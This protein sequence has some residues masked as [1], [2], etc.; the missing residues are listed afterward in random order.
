MPDRDD[1]SQP[2]AADTSGYP[3]YAGDTT[4]VD[5]QPQTTTDLDVASGDEL[6]RYTGG[7][8]PVDVLD[9]P[10]L[11]ADFYTATDAGGYA[12]T[13][14]YRPVMV[15]GIAVTGPC[16]L[17][18]YNFIDTTTGATAFLV[19]IHDGLDA[20]APPVAYVN[21]SNPQSWPNLPLR[22]RFGCYIEFVSGTPRGHIYT[23]G[24]RAK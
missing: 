12:T 10:N 9:D 11:A 23:V 8:A 4:M 13:G 16:Y 19:I 7:V 6:A 1:I 3:S 5:S 2:P 20:A 14:D 17:A 24:S 21:L 15:S 18:G 22:L